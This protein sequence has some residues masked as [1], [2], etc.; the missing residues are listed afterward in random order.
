MQR[1][2]RRG[3]SCRVHV[4]Q[5]WVATSTSKTC[6]VDAVRRPPCTA[7][8]P[9]VHA[10]RCTH[11]A[12]YGYKCFNGPQSWLLGWVEATPTFLYGLSDPQRTE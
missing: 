7:R 12:Q 3:P 10:V 5:L 8:L 2:A 11:C 6:C 9:T 4:C 1:S